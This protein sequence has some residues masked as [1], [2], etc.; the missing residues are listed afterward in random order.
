MFPFLS[1]QTATKYTGCYG[2][3]E[4]FKPFNWKKSSICISCHEAWSS[5]TPADRDI[6]SHSVTTQC[7]QRAVIQ[8]AQI[9]TYR[10]WECSSSVCWWGTW[11]PLLLL[12][13]HCVT[14]QIP[15]ATLVSFITGSDGSAATSGVPPLQ[16]QGLS[17]LKGQWCCPEASSPRAVMV[18]C[19]AA[20][21]VTHA[22]LYNAFLVSEMWRF[23]LGHKLKAWPTSIARIPGVACSMYKYSHLGKALGKISGVGKSRVK[24]SFLWSWKWWQYRDN[25]REYFPHLYRPM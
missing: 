24:L 19:P 13:R 8:D 6:G 4:R 2:N 5:F 18:L 22:R 17:P 12:Y 20:N 23:C 14:F 16:E 9:K 7:A 25:I 10:P 11:R 15:P 1:L 21:P 3:L